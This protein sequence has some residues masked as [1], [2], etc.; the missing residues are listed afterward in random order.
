LPRHIHVVKGRM[1]PRGYGHRLDARSL[2]GLPQYHGYEWRRTG[3]D[4][5]LIAVT[6]GIVYTILRGVLN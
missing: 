2:R 5:V 6:S 1:L 4:I 3:S